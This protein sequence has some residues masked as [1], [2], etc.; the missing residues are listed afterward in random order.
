MFLPLNKLEFDILLAIAIITLIIAVLTAVAG[1]A[2]FSEDTITTLSKAS[3]WMTWIVCAG[4]IVGTVHM[5]MRCKK[6][7]DPY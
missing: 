3:S 7:S 4:S 2:G 1:Y 5:F 6:Y